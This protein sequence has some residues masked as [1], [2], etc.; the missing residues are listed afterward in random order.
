MTADIA[1]AIHAAD[2][3]SLGRMV[4]VAATATDIVDFARGCGIGS[5]PGRRR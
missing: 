1:A 4:G 5:N 3:A 2:E